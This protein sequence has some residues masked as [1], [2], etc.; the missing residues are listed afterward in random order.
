MPFADIILLLLQP[1]VMKNEPLDSNCGAVDTF[2]LVFP[3]ARNITVKLEPSLQ[4]ERS[5]LVFFSTS[6]TNNSSNHLP[7]LLFGDEPS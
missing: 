4:T 6:S 5:L 7:R 3:P 2:V 1:D